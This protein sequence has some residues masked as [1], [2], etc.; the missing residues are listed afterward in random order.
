[1]IISNRL[2]YRGK[3]SRIPLMVIIGYQGFHWFMESNYVDLLVG[4]IGSLGVSTKID[5]LRCNKENAMTTTERLIGGGNFCECSRNMMSYGRRRIT[6]LV[7][8]K[9]LKTR[10]IGQEYG[11][12]KKPSKAKL[13]EINATITNVPN[14]KN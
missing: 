3:T 6:S 12:I 1:M 9:T 11:E 2:V 10:M 7:R 5:Q 13:V 8:A 4:D 14:A